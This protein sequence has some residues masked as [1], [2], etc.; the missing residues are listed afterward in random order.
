MRWARGLFKREWVF[1]NSFI[2]L[3]IGKGRIFEC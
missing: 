2:R 1:F 3:I